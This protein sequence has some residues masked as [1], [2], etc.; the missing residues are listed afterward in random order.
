MKVNVAITKILVFRKRGPLRQDEIWNY[1]DQLLEDVQEFNYVGVVF[2]VS[3]LFHLN[4]QY[5]TGKA[6]RASSMLLHNLFK[7]EVKP[8][9]VLQVLDT[10]VGSVLTIGCPVWGFTKSKDIERVQMKFCKSV[11]GVKQTTSTTAIYGELGR[12]PF[13]INRLT[14]IVKYWLKLTKT[15][16]IILQTLLKSMIDDDD[17]G[18]KN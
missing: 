17:N 11:L 15:E 8:S 9:I 1:N 7:Y 2:N 14:A 6:L 18:L 3:G 5:V 4:N 10:F 16:H 13:N 12:F